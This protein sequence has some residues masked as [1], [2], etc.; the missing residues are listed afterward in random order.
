[1]FLKPLASEKIVKLIDIDNT[2]VFIVSRNATKSEI[3]DNIEKI[4]KVKVSGVR[5]SLQANQKKAYVRFKKE[6]PAIDIATKLG[7]I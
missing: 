1:M 5:T 7:L 3:K 2:L 6:Y 4:F